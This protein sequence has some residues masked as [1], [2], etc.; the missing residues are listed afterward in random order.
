N[1][2]QPHSLLAVTS[3]QTAGTIEGHPAND[4]VFGNRAR[5]IKP[6]QKREA[7]SRGYAIVEPGDVL[8]TH[9]AEICRRHADE[10]LTRDATKHLLDE[11]R[12][13]SPAVVD[14]IIPGVLSLAE[15]QTILQLLLR[16]QVSIRQLGLI[17]EALGDFASRSKDPILLTE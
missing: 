2:V 1:E 10:L 9:L 12:T 5:W 6:E 13:S 8:A 16:E 3:D 14:E 11:L 17:L 15:V 4:S 7:K